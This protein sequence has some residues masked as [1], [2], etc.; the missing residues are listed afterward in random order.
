MRNKRANS[1]VKE[2]PLLSSS[3]TRNSKRERGSDKANERDRISDDSCA[4]AYF[5]AAPLPRRN[6]IRVDRAEKSVLR[7]RARGPLVRV[8]FAARRVHVPR[9]MPST[10]RE[11]KAGAPVVALP[12]RVWRVRPGDRKTENFASL[13]LIISHGEVG[14]L[15]GV[16]PPAAHSTVAST[17]ALP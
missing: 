12:P 16:C 13:E 6:V 15:S 10:P 9:S 5:L 17:L 4:T 2:R 11:Q 7:A 14:S 8:R 1:V 3:L